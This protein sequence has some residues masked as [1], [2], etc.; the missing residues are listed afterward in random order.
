MHQLLPN[1]FLGDDFMTDVVLEVAIAWL[2]A[3]S[4]GCMD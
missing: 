2:R 4:G 3:C 1:D